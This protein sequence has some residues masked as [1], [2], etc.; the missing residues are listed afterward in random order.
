MNKSSLHTAWAAAGLI[1]TVTAGSPVWADDV[2]LLLSVPGASEAAKPNVLFILDSSGS[3]TS[4]ET[5]QTP[6]DSTVTYSGSCNTSYLYWSTN[7]NLPSCSS[8][9]IRRFE[10][11]KFACAQGLA[12]IADAGS[13]SD[14][15]AQYRKRKGSWKW[16]KLSRNETDKW[17]ECAADSGVHGNGSFGDVYARIG[18]NVSM[19]T[20]NPNDEVDWASSPTNQIVTVYDA[21][22]I[23]WFN[24]PPASSMSRTDIVK[25]V[26]QNVLGSINDVNVGFM[27]F[28]NNEGGPVIHAV[29]DLD[30]N[31]AQANAVV[32]ALPASGW[33]PLGE[34]MYEAARYWR[35][36]S[37]HYGQL[38]STDSDA[39]IVGDDSKYRQP[40]EYACAKNFNVLL[41]DGQP[42][43]DLGAYPLVSS[44]PEFSATMGSSVCTGGNANGACLDDIAEYLSR[45]DINPGVDGAQ[46][47]TTYTIGF[48]VDLPIL[49]ATAE[50]SGGK[51]YLAEDVQSLTVALT[52][53]V[54]NIFDRDISFTAPA[55]A[56]NAFN[57]TQHLND[58]YV[59][60]F[61]ATDRHHWPGNLKKYRI[62]NSR[63]EDQFDKDAIDPDTG[64][65]AD[66]ASNYWNYSMN[67]DGADVY[68]GGAANLLPEPALR[69]LYTNNGASDL[70]QGS[71]HVSTANL[72]SFT[73]AD[74]GLSGGSGEPDLMTIIDWARGADTKD[75]DNDPYTLT[76]EAMGDTLH[77][78]PA[79]IVYGLDANGDPD[80][81][82]FSAT[83]NG[84]L[85]ATD[86]KTGSELWSFIPRDMLANLADLYLNENINYKTYGI[87]GDIIPLVADRNKNGIIE[88]G[89]DFVYLFFGLRRGGDTYWALDVTDKNAPKLKWSRTFDQLGQSWSPVSAARI[90][91]NS[92]KQTSADKAVL[93]LGA[94]YDT[95]HDAAPHPS[96]PDAQGAGI[97]M[98]DVE[99]GDVIWRAGLDA[100]ADLTLPTMTRAI[101]GRIRV[102]DLT[103]DNYADRLYAA[104]MGGQIWR[105]DIKN[106]Q[107]PANLVTGGVIA[108]FGAEGLN[109]PTP[110][111]TRRFYT[112][113][114][115]SMVRDAAQDRRYLAV[116]IGSGYRAHPLNN[117]AQDRFYS[118]RDYDVFRDLT[119]AEYDSY[120][121]A[122]NADMV[123]VSGQLNA[124]ILPGKR[125]WMFSLRP[126]EKILSDSTTFNNVI[127]FVSFEPQVA[128]ADPC[129]AGLS[130]NRLYRVEVLDGD[131]PV[132]SESVDPN[133]PLEVNEQRVTKLAQGGIAPKP[134]FLFPSP[135]NSSC[136]GEECRPPPL[137]CVGVECFDPGFANSPVRTLWTQDGV[138]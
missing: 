100:G 93:V 42:T 16:Q 131:P 61:R 110:A 12:Q 114:D 59:S 120:P 32:Q 48:T 34:T 3:M 108:R 30:S 29:K 71:N 33:T 46:T 135:N 67:Q 125:G 26:T 127:Y 51:Y 18:S 136:V 62:A 23:N 7:S 52:D 101:P 31:R 15:M 83:N 68:V 117:S 138:D 134:Q 53:I 79:S 81:V 41:T 47:V 84:Y 44:L 64:F 118:L 77:S 72:M 124:T 78:Q 106:A 56:V 14:T 4:I 20:S 86:G 50:N 132:L 102:L 60:V 130:I 126:G 98:L 45:S 113:P 122:T 95:V 129:Q 111:Q 13:Y 2:E 112:T 58:L 107:T 82:V 105:F 90:D 103:G 137:G 74:F 28:H 85:H 6:Y 11:S 8:G 94:G 88:P 123:E 27:R 39:L 104:D 97:L 66:E 1:A 80:I 63:I 35:G 99:T 109:N 92:P 55:I 36:L 24:S 87:D 119:Q 70:T 96:A 10:K 76:R 17:V 65:F 19:F 133:D 5:T 25:A 121:I 49:K 38:G 21:N 128:S 116:S 54:T 69:N 9:T 91:I 75:E 37:R 43:Q 89:T 57:R 22:Y 40:A 73:L 115:V